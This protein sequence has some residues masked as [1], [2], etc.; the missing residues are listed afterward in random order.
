MAYEFSKIVGQCKKY[1]EK[2]GKFCVLQ[3][4]ASFVNSRET[5]VQPP[6]VTSI[7]QIKWK[8]KKRLLQQTEN[9]LI[10]PDQT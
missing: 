6:T 5:H 2:K 8:Q 7:V 3:Y 10:N 4:I 9:V 1:K